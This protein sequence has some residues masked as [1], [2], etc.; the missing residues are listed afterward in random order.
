MGGERT[1]TNM[2]ANQENEE[3]TR[4]VNSELRALIITTTDLT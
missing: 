3:G 1:R 2:K 4:G